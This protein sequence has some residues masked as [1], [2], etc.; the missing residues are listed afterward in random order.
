MPL[1]QL[2]WWWLHWLSVKSGLA[3]IY[4]SKTF[5]SF[6]TTCVLLSANPLF[7]CFLCLLVERALVQINCCSLGKSRLI[8]DLSCCDMAIWHGMAH[9]HRGPVIKGVTG[10]SRTV[11]SFHTHTN[12][13]R[14]TS[15]RITSYSSISYPTV[16]S[17]HLNLCTAI[18]STNQFPS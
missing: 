18:I 8:D 6:T 4:S 12:S 16:S 1:E 15:L 7:D 5:Q 10:V 9:C 11:H 17:E 14:I 13:L 3:V 2:G